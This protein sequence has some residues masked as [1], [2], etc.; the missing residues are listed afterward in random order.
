MNKSNASKYQNARDW[1]MW[2]ERISDDDIVQTENI[3]QGNLEDSVRG[4]GGDYTR[5]A[6]HK[7][8]NPL[9]CGSSSCREMVNLFEW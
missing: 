9:F 3:S 7:V 6:V 1:H 2:E 5:V 8:F 4:S